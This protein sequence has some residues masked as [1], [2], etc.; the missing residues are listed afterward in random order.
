MNPALV[1]PLSMGEL[2]GVALRTNNHFSPHFE[3]VKNK[4]LAPH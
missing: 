2:E 1:L 3:Q 4:F